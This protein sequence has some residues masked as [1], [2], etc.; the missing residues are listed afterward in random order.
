M[1]FRLARTAAKE[2]LISGSSASA[3]ASSSYAAPSSLVPSTRVLGTALKPVRTH[4]HVAFPDTA[5]AAASSGAAASA[6]GS[7]FEFATIAAD[8]GADDS[9]LSASASIAPPAPAR[10]P[11]H[12]GMS[13]LLALGASGALTDMA[14]ATVVAA[15][16]PMG[17]TPAFTNMRSARAPVSVMAPRSPGAAAF[18]TFLPKTPGP[19]DSRRPRGARRNEMVYHVLVSE[20]GSP[21]REA[22]DDEPP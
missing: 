11:A 20:N 22:E 12:G 6:S 3:S 15:A 8:Q 18:S 1:L 17:R 16:L 10:T 14:S 2:R 4:H 21:L 5:A 13:R 7:D 19:D 9:A